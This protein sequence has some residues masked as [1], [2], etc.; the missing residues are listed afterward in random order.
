ML[1]TLDLMVEESNND[2]PK[3]NQIKARK[4]VDLVWQKGEKHR[5][6]QEIIKNR[7]EH[8]WKSKR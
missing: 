4:I 3:E 8:L 7:Q 2:G 6:W 5:N 1:S